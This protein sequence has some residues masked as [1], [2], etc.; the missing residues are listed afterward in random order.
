MEITFVD[1]KKALN[2]ANAYFEMACILY[3]PDMDNSILNSFNE[4]IE[5]ACE[6][7]VMANY[8][9]INMGENMTMDEYHNRTNIVDVEDRRLSVFV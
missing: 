1:Y 6:Q 8:Y 9:R 5:L 3:K 7:L 2:Y 4:R